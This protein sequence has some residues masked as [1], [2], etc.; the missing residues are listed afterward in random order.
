MNDRWRDD[1]RRRWEERERERERSLRGGR[2]YGDEG[3]S[4]NS[5]YQSGDYGRDENRGERRSFF[6][7]SDYSRTE[8]YQRNAGGR[9]QN[10]SRNRSLGG[11]YRGIDYR[12]GDYYGATWGASDRDA[13][14]EPY[15]GEW[16]GGPQ[17]GFNRPGESYDARRRE[18]YAEG[19]YGR[20]QGYGG[21][22]DYEGYARNQHHRED[23]S[24]VDKARDEVGAWFGDHEAEE[25][26]RRDAARAGHPYEARRDDTG[27]SDR[28]S[29]ED[30]Y[31][32]EQSDR[33]D[34]WNRNDW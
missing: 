7:G 8:D 20:D 32:S 1:D 9:D 21:D 18:T 22:R 4:R 15:R 30:R 33:R 17:S 27:W 24:W 6:G 16:G 19:G 3:Y 25:R 5:G 23:R 26:R 29:G 11:D 13:G 2:G 12:E 10:Y 28:F 14:R 31:R 34:R